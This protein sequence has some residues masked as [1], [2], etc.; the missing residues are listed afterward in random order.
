[1]KAETFIVPVLITA[2]LVSLLSNGRADDFSGA[3]D[4]RTVLAPASLFKGVSATART[5]RIDR[6][7]WL[8][9]TPGRERESRVVS[10][11]GEELLLST[12]INGDILEFPVR[13]SFDEEGILQ[14][15]LPSWLLV[16]PNKD[17]R[18]AM[19]TLL[20]FFAR[21]T[22]ENIFS[23]S[24]AMFSKHATVEGMRGGD[25]TVSISATTSALTTP[26]FKP[27]SIDTDSSPREIK[28]AAST[29]TSKA[30]I[31]N[32]CPK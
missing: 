27:F 12:R 29:S 9:I 22:P 5:V 17:L 28:T 19:R 16:V 14:V 21:P 7:N 25:N 3:P 26:K 2:M 20:D 6:E 30:R 11:S 31:S 23:S 10:Q 4:A 8:K 13:C 24:H 1:M 32:T 18:N 15:D